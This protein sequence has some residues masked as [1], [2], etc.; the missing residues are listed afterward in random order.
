MATVGGPVAKKRRIS[1]ST[2]STVT[3][4]SSECTTGEEAEKSD[5]E[6]E[7]AQRE[8]GSKR[9]L[10][11]SL[12]FDEYGKLFQYRITGL[13]ISKSRL[14]APWN[15]CVWVMI[16]PVSRLLNC[17]LCSWSPSVR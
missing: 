16:G 7:D 4:A 17:V 6:T 8:V 1:T 11:V 14:C 2:V 15:L 13:L 10:C 3:T 12:N 5:E 9:V